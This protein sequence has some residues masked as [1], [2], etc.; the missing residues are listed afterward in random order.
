MYGEVR[1]TENAL[2]CSREKTCDV[3]PQTLDGIGKETDR[4]RR[5]QC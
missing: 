3:S 4:G 5:T 2:S 1:L